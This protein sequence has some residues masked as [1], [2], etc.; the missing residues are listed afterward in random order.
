M[1]GRKFL[2]L[3]PESMKEYLLSRKFGLNEIGG[4]GLKGIISG[5]RC[6]RVLKKARPI[7]YL[8]FKAVQNP[9]ELSRYQAIIESAEV[10][11]EISFSILRSRRKKHTLENLE[12]NK[13]N[14]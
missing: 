1:T 4:L 3:E 14:K 13:Y 10:K 8:Y 6:G 5:W 12:I 7:F 11:V 9:E 2:A